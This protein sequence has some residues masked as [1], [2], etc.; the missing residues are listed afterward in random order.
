MVCGQYKRT[1]ENHGTW[2]FPERKPYEDHQTVWPIVDN[3]R[4]QWLP[5]PK[6]IES[7]GD[8]QKH[9]Q[10]QNFYHCSSLKMILY[11]DDDQERRWQKYCMTAAVVGLPILN[12]WEVGPII[13]HNKYHDHHHHQNYILRCNCACITILLGCL[14]VARVLYHCNL[15]SG[16]V[17]QFESTV[18]SH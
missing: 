17:L 7:N 2:W 8:P 6:A 13:N 1:I 4:S 16:S 18:I 9:Y 12:V 5:H 3:Q 14:T 11:N 15:P 10:F